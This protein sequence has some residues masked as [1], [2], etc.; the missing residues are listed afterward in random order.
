M[1]DH[2]RDG[3]FILVPF[4][5]VAPILIGDFEML[6]FG[7]LPFLESSEL[8][9]FGDAEPELDDDT[10]ALYKLFLKVVDLDRKSVV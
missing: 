1:V 3:Y 9:V 5:A 4:L 6:E 7:N 2:L 10:A 8:F